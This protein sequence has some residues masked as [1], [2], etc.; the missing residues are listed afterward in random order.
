MLT[1]L[2]KPLCLFP[3]TSVSTFARSWVLQRPGCKM[4][5]V[6]SVLD[7]IINPLEVQKEDRALAICICTVIGDFGVKLR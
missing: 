4:L 6:R 5:G 2:Y 3:A 1:H 7:G